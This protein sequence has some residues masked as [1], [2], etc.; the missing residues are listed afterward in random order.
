MIVR[1]IY[2][3][4]GLKLV[5]RLSNTFIE[6]KQAMCDMVLLHIPQWEETFLVY[7]DTSVLGFGGRALPTLS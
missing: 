7:I 3:V 6:V 1:S 4:T 2:V 5:R